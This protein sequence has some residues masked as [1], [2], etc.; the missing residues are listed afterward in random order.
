MC[1]CATMR[2]SLASPARI[3]RCKDT[4]SQACTRFQRQFFA[5]RMLPGACAESVALGRVCAICGAGICPLT[6]TLQQKHRLLH[7][8]ANS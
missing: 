3:L 1:G 8:H 7:R 6:S 5:G 4:T 2:I